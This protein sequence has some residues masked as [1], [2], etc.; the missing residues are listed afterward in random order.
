[1]LAAFEWRGVFWFLTAAAFFICLPMVVFLVKD[2]PSKDKRVSM[3]ELHHIQSGQ[4]SKTGKSG[5]NNIRTT[6]KFGLVV[7]SFGVN[8]LGVYGL[9]TWFP[10]YLANAKHF[11][12]QLTSFYMLFAYALA[13][14]ITIWIGMHTDKTGKKAVWTLLG[15]SGAAV[16]LFLGSQIASPVAD[17]LL[18][19]GALT[20]LQGFTTPMIHGIMHSMS[21][22]EEI[23][24]NTGIMSGVAN[25]IAAFVPATMGALITLGHGSYMYAFSL[26]IFAFLLAA[27]TGWLL[28]RRGY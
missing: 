10:S 5:E 22:T 26:L 9:A 8:I 1:L 19:G 14:C 18:V 17:A 20:F 13:L 3:Q 12:P 27:L 16:F 23:G 15:Y 21:A 4:L 7:F 6:L 25:I 28:K 2:E 24:K 11:S